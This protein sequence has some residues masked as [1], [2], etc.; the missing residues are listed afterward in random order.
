M[1]QCSPLLAVGGAGKKHGLGAVGAGAALHA[2]ASRLV[3]L[4]ATECVVVSSDVGVALA[5]KVGD[6]AEGSALQAGDAGGVV[7]AAGAG[8]GGQAQVGVGIVG[9]AVDRGRSTAGA[10][11]ALRAA[12]GKGA[13]VS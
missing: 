10:C 2:G 7:V 6:G 9:C 3:P 5:V 8:T 13:G 12:A 4:V 11:L 1:L